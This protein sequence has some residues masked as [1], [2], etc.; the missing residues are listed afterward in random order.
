[1]YA[2]DEIYSDEITSPREDGSDQYPATNESVQ[3]DVAHILEATV[4]LE[5]VGDPELVSIVGPELAKLRELLRKIAEG[6][7]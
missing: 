2:G 7:Y 5:L 1:M 4:E 3:A 6:E